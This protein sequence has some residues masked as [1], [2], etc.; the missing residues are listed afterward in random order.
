MS[1]TD[2]DGMV[3]DFAE[4]AVLKQPA[5]Q[6]GC[7]IF[8]F[9]DAGRLLMMQRGPKCRHQQFKWEVPGGAVDEGESYEAAI[10]REVMEE[11]G[12]EVTLDGLIARYAE[13]VDSN[14]DRWEAE[15]FR[16]STQ[17]QPVI[18]EP[19]K[20]VGLGWF[21]KEEVLA[22]NRADYIDKD[23]RSLGWL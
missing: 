8:I 22:L 2:G 1:D 7:G 16:G 21:N 13:I 20:C 11:I 23:L 12:I 9:D 15:I 6:R 18:Q 4:A 14:G 17:Q 19:D 10:H 5:L 3:D